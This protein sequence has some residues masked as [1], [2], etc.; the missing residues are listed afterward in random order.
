MRSHLL[1][2]QLQWLPLQAG[3]K[4]D[5]LMHRAMLPPV[6][7]KT[8]LKVSQ[9]ESLSNPIQAEQPIISF[10]DLILMERSRGEH[11]ILIG[12]K[13]SYFLPMEQ[14]RPWLLRFI[15]VGE[16]RLTMS[17]MFMFHLDRWMY[18]LEICSNCRYWLIVAT[19]SFGSQYRQIYHWKCTQESWMIFLR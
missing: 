13:I 16:N 14:T 11:W 10:T 18:L 1:K 17:G 19:G 2:T 5:V 15:T 7:F 12:M 6:A 8:N 3:E 9:S 4:I